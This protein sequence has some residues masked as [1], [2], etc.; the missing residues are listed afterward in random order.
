MTFSPKLSIDIPRAVSSFEPYI[1]EFELRN[2]VYKILFRGK[3]LEFDSFREYAADDDAAVIDWLASLKSNRLLVKRYIEERDRK[4]LI[5]LDVSDQMIFGSTRQLKCEFAAEIAAVLGYL[6]TTSD[7]NLGFLFFSDRLKE[8]VPPKKGLGQF[9]YF[10]R[11]LE[12]TQYYGGPSNTEALFD[13]LLDSVPKDV[14]AVI[15]IS[16]FMHVSTECQRKLRLISSRFE[17][18]AIMVRDPLDRALPMESTEVVLE[19]PVSHQQVLVNPKIYAAEYTLHARQQEEAVREMFKKSGI[20]LLQ[21]FTSDTFFLPL[22]VFLKD[23]VDRRG[24]R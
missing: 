5:A 11:L 4:I 23:R 8:Y 21:L 19:D 12:S 13:Y 7:D 2:K 14:E 1:K 10:S 18:F 9:E 16:D 15:I 20:D 3:G 24:F 22:A 17:S 6:V